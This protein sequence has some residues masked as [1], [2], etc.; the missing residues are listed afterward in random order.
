MSRSFGPACGGAANP[1]SASRPR[2]SSVAMAISAAST[3]SAFR[4]SALT[5]ISVT[6]SA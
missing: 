4:T 1:I 6:E 3:P 5:C 2:F